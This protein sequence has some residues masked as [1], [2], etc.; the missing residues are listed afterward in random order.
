V[1]LL[2]ILELVCGIVVLP[3]SADDTRYDYEPAESRGAS[4][5]VLGYLVQYV[6]FVAW[7][8]WM[9]WVIVVQ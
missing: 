4:P 8:L 1:A 9:G 3:W 6:L 2:G 7:L 5:N